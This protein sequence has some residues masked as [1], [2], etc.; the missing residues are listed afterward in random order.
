MDP[1]DLLFKYGWF[2]F[3]ALNLVG[4]VYVFTTLDTRAAKYIGHEAEAKR[5]ILGS[6]LYLTPIY[7]LLGAVQLLGRYSTV[8]YIFLAPLD[9]PLII[10]MLV[11]LVCYYASLGYWLWFRNGAGLLIRYQ[12]WQG[13]GANN[14]TTLKFLVSFILVG[15]TFSVILARFVFP[16]FPY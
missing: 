1:F 8:F 14:E 2:I 15:V 12:L 3:G 11:F 16:P 9:N 7:F 4:V 5:L 10:S 13:V 6:S